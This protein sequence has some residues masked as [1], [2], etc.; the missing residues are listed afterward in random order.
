MA[1]VHGAYGGMAAAA[2]AAAGAAAAGAW[3][4]VVAL[5]LILTGAALPSPAYAN[6][7]QAV[8]EVFQKYGNQWSGMTDTYRYCLE[9]E[10][11]GA[12]LPAAAEE[13]DELDA[14]NGRFYFT[15]HG[16]DN[17]G[18]PEAPARRLSITLDDADGWMDRTNVEYCLF[19][20]SEPEPDFA[21]HRVYDNNP[22]ASEVDDLLEGTPE[23]VAERMRETTE[24]SVSLYPS[25]SIE[26]QDVF[27]TVANNQLQKV[28]NPGWQI[29]FEGTEGTVH[30]RANR[31]NVK[32]VELE[33]QED[34]EITQTWN[35]GETRNLR[36]NTFENGANRFVG[37]NT[38]PDGSGSAYA[39]EQEYYMTPQ[40]LTLYAQWEE[41]REDP[42][43]GSKTSKD[44]TRG[45]KGTS[46]SD[47]GSSF[48]GDQVP[49]A[50]GLSGGNAA[51]NP[52]AGAVKSIFPKTGDVEATVIAVAF[53]AVVAAA[54]AFTVVYA[55][56]RRNGGVQEK[57]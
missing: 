46:G 41:P 35:L 37:W 31:Q 18:T 51:S 22:E 53:M 10:T 30:F 15:L 49:G 1:K 48:V 39:D 55:R 11:E 57:Q 47:E 33:V 32:K 27:L 7:G 2:G 9:A 34:E 13:G 25:I 17:A 44:G 42:V 8:I 26:G 16:N 23:E 5:A 38:S 40:G 14:E 36:K 29:D 45:A 24:F 6:D 56:R 19:M 50:P 43:A 28:A 54:A 20:S 21:Y 3:A 12:P 52:L 4:L